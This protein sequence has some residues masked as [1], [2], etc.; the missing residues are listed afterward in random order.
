M[1]NTSVIVK[2]KN[3][4]VSL[5]HPNIVDN[6]ICDYSDIGKND[7]LKIKEINEELTKGIP[8]GIL[9][10]AG[11]FSS[12]TKEAR[13][14][15]SSKHFQKKTVAKAIIVASLGQRVVAR[16]YVKVNKPHIRTKIFAERQPALE[17]LQQEMKKF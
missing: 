5:I 14:L 8:Y 11:E 2:E 10:S 7:I 16:F 13:E 3:L 9:V 12:I 4:T 1:Q 17:W 15:S 6:T